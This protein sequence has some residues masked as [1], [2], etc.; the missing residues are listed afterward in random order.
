[1]RMKGNVTILSLALVL[2]ACSKR[3]E[4]TAALS[5]D[6][7]KDLAAASAS[8][9]DLVAAPQNYQRMR[10]VSAIE[11]SEA[12]VAKRSKP[13]RHSAHTAPNVAPDPM[14]AMMSNTPMTVSTVSTS[15]AESAVTVRTAPE[16]AVVP[17]GRTTEE[18]GGGLGALLG[19]IVSNVVI[20]GG[21]VGDGKCDPRTD[22]RANGT[23]ANRPDFSMPIP[24]GQPVF[25][26]RR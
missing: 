14:A 9:K 26:R 18:G 24:T 21:R 20:R 4:P 15:S 11:Q 6:L 19:G 22:A 13:L 17:V 8:T 16:A 7:K 12:T 3:Q 5:D 10:F 1:M 25:G 2:S 23:I